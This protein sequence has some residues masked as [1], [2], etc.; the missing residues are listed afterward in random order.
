MSLLCV[1]VKKARIV[2]NDEN[3]NSYV[4]LKIDNV[5]STTSVVKGLNPG[6][7]QE[8]YFDVNDMVLGLQVELW[9]RGKF[10]DK[11]LGLYYVKLNEIATSSQNADERWI[12]LDGELVLSKNGQITGTC[13]PTEHRLLLRFFVELPADLTEEESKDL[14]QKLE[15]L[16]EILDKE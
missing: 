4:V 15:Y 3:C 10:W 5:K 6:W 9:D 16:N 8:F 14:Q 7:E 2:G 11:L 12:V 13:N 1:L